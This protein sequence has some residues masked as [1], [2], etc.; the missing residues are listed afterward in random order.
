MKKQTKKLF[1]IISLSIALVLGGVFIITS[2]FSNTHNHGIVIGGISIEEVDCSCG[3]GE[4]AVK[5]MCG[6]ARNELKKHGFDNDDIE[7][8]L[9]H[10]NNSV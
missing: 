6:T 8:Y 7:K 10:L 9:K 4:K 2:P 1:L 3:C 5:C